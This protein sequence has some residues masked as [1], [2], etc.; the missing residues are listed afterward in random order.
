MNF[1][2]DKNL[3][4]NINVS[5]FSIIAILHLWRAITGLSLYLGAVEIPVW[6][7]YLAVLVASFLAYLNYHV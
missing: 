7:S 5:V 1:N 4:K 2:F 6:G 3:I